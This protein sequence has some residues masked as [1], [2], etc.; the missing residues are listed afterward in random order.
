M[1]YPGTVVDTVGPL[2]LG[3]WYW[4]AI[5]RKHENS[6]GTGMFDTFMVG[7]IQTQQFL[8]I[9]NQTWPASTAMIPLDTKNLE[10][11]VNGYAGAHPGFDG[12]LR[13][14]A[15]GR[16]M[17]FSP[18]WE[19]FYR[20]GTAGAGMRSYLEILNLLVCSTEWQTTS[21][22]YLP[23]DSNTGQKLVDLGSQGLKGVFGLSTSS[24]IGDPI[25]DDVK[26]MI[27]KRFLITNC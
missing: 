19:A 15:V 1:S 12:T 9:G 14:I 10:I 5:S 11:L 23:F 4:F 7:S 13:N 25:F 2:S 21:L 20:L 18:I 24:T 8:A 26:F 17:F 22:L 27:K 6:D 3:T 16:G